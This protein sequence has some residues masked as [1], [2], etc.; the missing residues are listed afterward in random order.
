[1]KIKCYRI[2]NDEALYSKG[3]VTTIDTK[4]LS[5]GDVQVKVMYS[6]VNYKDALA[7]MGKGKILKK[8]PLNGGIDFSGTVISS[9][10]NNFKPGDEVLANGCGLSELTDGG[11]SEIVNIDSNFLIKKPEGL[12]SKECMVI[13]T[14][15]FTAALCVHRLEANG[16]SPDKGPILVT[17]ATGGVGSFA[18]NLFSKLGYEVIALTSKSQCHDFLTKLGA[19]KITSYERLGLDSPQKPLSKGLFGGVIDNLGGDVLTNLIPHT[20]LWGNIAS[21]GLAHGYKVQTTVMPFILRGV[22]ILGISSNN[23]DMELKKVLWNK[24]AKN[25]KPDCINMYKEISMNDLDECFTNMLDRK[26]WGRTIVKIN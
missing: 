11:Y 7:G 24:L 1:M 20:N 15:G 5:V 3:R 26:T 25:L 6:S 13:G 8:I 9:K 14:A 4:E 17:G 21:V 22:S 23:C 19:K 16:Q 10:V 2:Y 18:V 12:T